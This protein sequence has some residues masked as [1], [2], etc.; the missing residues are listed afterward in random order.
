MTCQIGV[1]LLEECTE[2]ARERRPGEALEAAA[3]RLRY[4]FLRRARAACGARWIAIGHHRDD[5]IETILLRL[6]FGSGITGVAGMLALSGDLVRPL[7]GLRRSDLQSAVE[8]AGL[9]FSQDPGN[10]NLSRPRN[11]IRHRLLPHLKSS[12]SFSSSQLLRLAAAAGDTTAAIRRRLATE[13]GARRLPGATQG[14]EL[15]RERF[16]TLPVA[17]RPF[18]LDV[19]SRLAGAEYL[20]PIAAQRDLDRQLAAGR[21]VGC[22]CGRGWS[23]RGRGTKLQLTRKKRHE[24]ADFSYRLEVPGELC[25]PELGLM[26]HLTQARPAPWMFR[27]SHSRAA[28]SL[29]LKAGQQVLIRNRRPGDRLRPLGCSYERKLK[30]VLIDRGI[31]RTERDRLPL[32]IVGGRLAWVPGVTIDDSLRVEGSGRVWVAELKPAE[33]R[34]MV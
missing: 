15:D 31:A 14:A 9:P 18:A 24:R 34:T 7:L 27:G 28:M 12:T 13:L 6:L 5:Q 33:R 26:L 32:L 2:V 16:T 29:P 20:A 8:A 1:Q 19:L 17:L 3:R 4:D 21:R 23:W 30:D 22:D 10:N 11:L 25:I